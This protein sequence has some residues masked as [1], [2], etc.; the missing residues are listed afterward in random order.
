MISNVIRTDEKAMMDI[1]II[2][3]LSLAAM[4]SFLKS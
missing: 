1:L 3:M 4:Y 2:N